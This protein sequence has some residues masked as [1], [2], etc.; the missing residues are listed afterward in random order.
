MA[1]D[2][3]PFDDLLKK[4]LQRDLLFRVF[5]WAIIAGLTA[6]YASSRPNFSA[7]EFFARVAATVM[8]VLNVIGVTAIFLSVFA[9]LFKDLEALHPEWWGSRRRLAMAT[10][11]VRRT[12]GDLT[13]WVIGALVTV[14]AAATVGV[15]SE[16]V[17][18][19]ASTSDLARVGLL[20]ITLVMMLIVVG[21]LN[22]MVR[23]IDPP[24]ATK[25]NVSKRFVKAGWL[26]LFYLSAFMFLAWSIM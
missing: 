25:D 8:P 7:V 18:G 16:F 23:R 15:T 2:K 5:I 4:K 6:Y 20:Y 10:G 24:I 1:T 26:T 9:L 3:N 13:L 22:V 21:F 19:R 12:S 11:V 17:G 14:L